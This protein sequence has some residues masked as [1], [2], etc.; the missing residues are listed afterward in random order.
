MRILKD[1]K[2]IKIFANIFFIIF[3]LT[4]IVPFLLLVSISFTDQDT[5][6]QYGAHLIP[7]VWS[8]QAYK[9]I[10]KVPGEMLYHMLFTMIIAL[11]V[12][13]GQALV[14][15]MFGYALSHDD[16]VAK[17][18]FDG[19]LIYA[20]LIGGGLIPMYV[21]VKNI[22]HLDGII[23]FYLLGLT[24]SWSVILYRTFFKGIPHSL[25]ESARL[26][27]ATEFQILMHVVFPM[28]KSMYGIQYFT[29]T[30]GFWNNW[31]TNLIW[32]N[33][34]KK[35]WTI[36]YYL[37]KMLSDFEQIK[38]AYVEAGLETS[39]KIP[40]TTIKYAS[41]VLALIPIF[42]VFPKISKTFSKGVA[43]GSVKG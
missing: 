4:I 36:Q 15:S 34:D 20:M 2:G 28:S 41:C 11:T 18:F 13:I 9:V 32:L 27:G 14:S 43:I 24:S 10:F 29:A 3:S 19:Y 7:K 25:I 26:D 12:P 33:E 31:E 40:T 6:M 42:I 16:F 8:L 35:I 23:L 21:V 5:L 39:F 38:A 37:Q 1:G 30:I 17:K 22:Y